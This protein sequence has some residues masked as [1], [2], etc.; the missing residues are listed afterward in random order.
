MLMYLSSGHMT[1]QGGEFQHS[2][3]YDAGQTDVGL[4]PK[5]LVNFAMSLS[6]FANVWHENK[7][8]PPW[9]LK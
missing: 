4:C 1:V 9:N 3:T 5:F 2:Q 7:K 8:M 6:G